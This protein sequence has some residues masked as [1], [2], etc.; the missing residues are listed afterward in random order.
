MDYVRIDSL[1]GREGNM[2]RRLTA[3]LVV[4][5]VRSK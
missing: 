3:E 5:L 4:E 2:V 1:S